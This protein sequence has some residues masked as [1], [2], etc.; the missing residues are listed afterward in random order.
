M[1]KF[2]FLIILSV[3]SFQNIL[4]THTKGGW[5]YYK[6]LGPG[7]S[8][9]AKHRYRVGL[10]YYIDCNSNIVENLFSFTIFNGA[11]PHDFV[12]SADAPLISQS[13]IENCNL[14]ACYPCINFI[15]T[16]CYKII[17]YEII[18]EL[19]PSA[20]GF[21]VSK[22]RCCRING[23]SNLVDPTNT[24]G[25]TY[26]INIPGVVAGIPNSHNNESPQ[27]RFNDTS[28]VCGNNLFSIDFSATDADGDSLVYSF[29]D[30][31]SGASSAE[32]N[33]IISATP[34]YAPVAYQFPFS[35]IQPLGGMSSINPVTG[36]ISGT[37]P[38]SGEY[39]ISICVDEYRG[40]IKLSSSRKELHLKIA[41]C[42]P[43]SATLDP[44]FTT[45]GDLT[46]AFSNQT[47]NPSIQNW[48]WSFG[49]PSSG[50]TDSSASQ[51]PTHTFSTAGV[52]TVKL[53]VNRGLPCIDSAFQVVNV[54]PGFFPGFAPLAPFCVG[55]PV[56][57]DDTTRTNF[58]TVSNWS[59]NFGDPSPQGDTSHLQDPSYTYN[60][61]GTYTVNLV[62]GNSK[63]CKDTVSRIISVVPS[64]LLTVFPRDTTYCGRDSLRLTATGTGTFSWAPNTFITGANTA[65]PFVFPTSQT[66]YFVTLDNLGCRTRDS[67]KVTPVIDLTS[68]IAASPPNICEGDTLTLTGSSNR[69]NVTWRWSPQAQLASSGSQITLAFPAANTTY[70]LT[71]RW[72]NNCIA[73]AT[74][75]ITVTPLALSNA[76]PDTS[77]CAGQTGITLNASGGTSYQWTPSAGLSNPNIA[78]PV[79]TPAVTTTY[80]V[81]V[82]VTGCSRRRPDTV[83]VTAR[84]KPFLQMPR[85]TLICAIDTLQLITG[86]VGNFA[87]TPGSSISNTISQ[88]PLVSPDVPTTYY[89]RLTD[90]FNCFINDSVFIDVKPDV[91]VN[92][93][94]DTSICGTQGFQLAAT[95]DGL[96]YSWWPA[97]GLSNPT[98]RNPIA[99]PTVTT[100]YTVTANIGKCQRSSD[101]NIRVAPIPNA[102]AGADSSVCIGFN[103]QLAAS[104]GS[105]FAW[106]PATYLSDP[107]IANPQVI[108]PQQSILYVLT[109]SDT[110]GCARTVKDSVFIRVIQK[111]NVNAG[112]SD[113]SI[114]EGEPLSLLATGG[115]SYVWTPGTW[116]NNANIP[117]P[118]SIP[119][120]S[121]IYTV[122]GINGAGCRGTDT[123]RVTVFELDADMYVPTAFTPNSDGVNDIIKPILLGMRKLNYFKIFNRYGE[124]V[125]ETRE[126]G[127]G[128]NGIYKG[129]PQNMSSFVWIAEGITFKNETRQKKGN[130][131]LIR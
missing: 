102:N 67:I 44:N 65:T 56:R 6:Y 63:G 29:C 62:S 92:A 80:I 121:I 74:K 20:A 19:T 8:D 47:D 36:I 111:L 104:G 93:G 91:T 10:N 120:G 59:W 83:V 127:K 69:T 103:A 32:P 58:G 14:S 109:V 84:P 77:Y 118:V 42:S 75:A 5:M 39:V 89:V 124:L 119:G 4:A 30:A 82:G 49:D 24:M 126:I 130:V 18:V 51:L 35:G 108:Q 23:I 3:I 37:A 85:D 129:K 79:A 78:N 70:T 2:Y 115:I 28:I 125:F 46:L 96:N 97:L 40:G 128:W 57:F 95:G 33:P 13:N 99:T 53:V 116:L 27:Y 123:I 60:I 71:T 16:I 41:D 86:G 117:N 1:K 105:I 50:A 15:P 45:C 81:S 131:I 101:I 25:A 61:P 98:I 34:P 113:T 38:A 107:T 68:S 94:N 122:T 66:K 48:F 54:F 43:V 11:A 31:F 22:Q 64:P 12:L 100:L 76:G 87:W 21:I 26:T 106:S 7:I 90:V 73:T 52:Y 88:N 9:P 110:L 17:N 114:V 55:Q 72:G 112:P